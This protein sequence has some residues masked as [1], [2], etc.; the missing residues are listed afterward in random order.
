MAMCV[1]FTRISMAQCKYLS[2]TLPV[3]WEEKNAVAVNTTTITASSSLD[4]KSNS[5]A[6][7]NVF[8]Y[9]HPPNSRFFLYYPIRFWYPSI[10]FC[11]YIR[12]NTIFHLGLL[13]LVF[14]SG[15][16]FFF[17]FCI[18]IDSRKFVSFFFVPNNK[19]MS[20]PLFYLQFTCNTLSLILWI[21]NKF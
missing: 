2:N 3:Q 6:S 17:W 9:Q 16:G 5:T 15:S 4:R 18:H 10:E 14:L 21:S 7:Q 20:A 12:R 1:M 19:W 11:W 13:V 8:N